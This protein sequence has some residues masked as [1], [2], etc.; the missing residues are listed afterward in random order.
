MNVRPVI[1]QLPGQNLSVFFSFFGFYFFFFSSMCFSRHVRYLGFC[2]SP[3]P[4]HGV[5][6]LGGG[7]QFNDKC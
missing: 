2:M 7:N 5:G 3:Q 1:V 6:K 4:G